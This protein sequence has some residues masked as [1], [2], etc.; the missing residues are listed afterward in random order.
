MLNAR[1]SALLHL[2]SPCI[3]LWKTGNDL[4][5][6]S[7]ARAIVSLSFRNDDT[8]TLVPPALS[9]LQ[10]IAISLLVGSKVVLK[11]QLIAICWHNSS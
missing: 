11:L 9:Y 5:L 1:F 8:D 2:S 6:H 4:S 10:L 3:C 7:I